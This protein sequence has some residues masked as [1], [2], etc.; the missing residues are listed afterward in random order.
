MTAVVQPGDRLLA[1]VAALREADRALLEPRL[2]GEDPVVELATP[3][4][5]AGE[6]PEPLELVRRRS[7]RRSGLGVEQLGGGHAVVGGGIALR[8][9]AAED[10]VEVCSS[11]SIVALRREAGAEQLAC[12]ALAKRRLGQREEVVRAAAQTTSGAISRAFGVSSSASHDPPGAE[13]RDVVRDHPV[14]VRRG[15]GARSRGR[16]TGSRGG[17]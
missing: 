13:R 4:R 16:R 11:R 6:D 7:G 17:M 8:A 5:R 9:A 2:G 14:E 1:R 10:D 15:V 12:D 3:R